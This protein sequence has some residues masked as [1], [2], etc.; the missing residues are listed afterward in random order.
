MN[1]LTAQFCIDCEEVFDAA[2]V[3]SLA[4]PRCAHRN[5]VRLQ[6]WLASIAGHELVAHYA[7][8]PRHYSSMPQIPPTPAMP[9]HPAPLR[10][11]KGGARC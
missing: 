7:G 8:P 3:P 2:A 11:L 1:L 9:R 4:C 6:P 5:T 10:I